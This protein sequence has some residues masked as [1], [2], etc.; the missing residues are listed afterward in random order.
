MLY[1]CSYTECTEETCTC[2]TPHEPTKACLV[3]LN[4]PVSRREVHCIPIQPSHAPPQTIQ[5]EVSGATVPNGN[6]TWYMAGYE[7]RKEERRLVDDELDKLNQEGKQ[8]LRDCQM[9][10]NEYKAYEANYRHL[11]ETVKK[12]QDI[13]TQNETRQTKLNLIDTL[14]E[15]EL[16]GEK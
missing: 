2:R 9:A 10:R 4:C 1:Q 11:F 13:I 7:A 15:K 3:C 6:Y 16:K 5:D 8:V 14:C 12:I